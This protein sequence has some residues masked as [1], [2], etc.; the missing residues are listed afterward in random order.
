MTTIP[1]TDKT[2]RVLLP[3]G[4][5]Y[6]EIRTDGINGPTGYPVV[7]VDVVSLARRTPAADGR[8]YEPRFDHDCGVILI[9]RPGSKL[10][11]DL[12]VAA[13]LEAHDAGNH[14]TCPATCPV[15]RNTAGH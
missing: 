8:L 15:I 2:L 5:G 10:A 3:D 14:S 12:R 4:I 9:G 11:G 7:G 6:V 13:V 1:M